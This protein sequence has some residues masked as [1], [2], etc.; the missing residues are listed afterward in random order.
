[1]SDPTNP[2][3]PRRRPRKGRRG[4]TLIELLVVIT[5]LGIIAS[6][7]GV[8]VVGQLQDAQVDATKVQMSELAKT[9]DLY[10]VKFNRY[11]STQEGL[12]AL[13]SPPEGKKPLMEKLPRDPWDG[14]YIFVSPGQHNPGK[15]DLQ[16]KG[17]DGQADTEDDITNWK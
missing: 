9:L 13:V 12:Q 15:F 16:S 3:R 5:I 4:L 1:M 6:I 17:P 11:P 8:A 2:N 7:I 14:D 10:K